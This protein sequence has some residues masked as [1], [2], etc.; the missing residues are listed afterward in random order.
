MLFQEKESEF[1]VSNEHIELKLVCEFTNIP[2][3]NVN[4][5]YI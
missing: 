1:L 3:A 2:L 5:R 4:Q